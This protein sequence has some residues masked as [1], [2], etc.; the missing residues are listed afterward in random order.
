MEN[1]REN[2]THCIKNIIFGMLHYKLNQNENPTT[3]I[4]LT[5][6]SNI[7]FQ[8][9]KTRERENKKSHKKI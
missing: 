7:I 4:P 2:G 8:T 6:L 9:L 5:K 1:H 3:P